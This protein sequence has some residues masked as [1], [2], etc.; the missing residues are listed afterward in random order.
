[1][2]YIW[3]VIEIVLLFSLLAPT[4]RWKC[5][6]KVT[7]FQ[8]IVFVLFYVKVL[9]FLGILINNAVKSRYYFNS[10][11]SSSQFQSFFVNFMWTIVFPDNPRWY[12]FLCQN[13]IS[14]LNNI[15]LCRFLKVGRSDKLY[16]YYRHFNLV[17]WCHQVHNLP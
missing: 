6:I 15:R 10:F 17:F 7:F 11:A 12:N 4:I 13:I 1:M 3:T 2:F 14:N 5:A 8:R 16:Y 9:N